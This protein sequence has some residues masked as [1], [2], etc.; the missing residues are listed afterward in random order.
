MAFEH[1]LGRSL[2]DIRKKRPPN[3]FQPFAQQGL[4]LDSVG[5]IPTPNVLADHD[6]TAGILN[7]ST[8]GVLSWAAES[9][10]EPVYDREGT[11]VDVQNT[12]SET[13]IYSK[14]VAAGALSTNKVLRLTMYGDALRNA[15]H[16]PTVKVKL[17]GTTV[18][19][20]VVLWG[21]NSATR[22]PWLMNLMIANLSASSQWVM[23]QIVTG[24]RG[25]MTTGVGDWASGAGLEGGLGVSSADPAVDTTAAC[26]LVVTVTWSGA[27]ASSSWRKRYAI[28]E[29]F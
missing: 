22:A 14:T 4:T 18:L 15:G 20:D 5:K 16:N 7:V 26:D 24:A 11:T 25:S 13:T 27:S 29:L 3:S 19:D 6:G 10:Y 28:L 12:T 17:G 21:S 8:A 2:E 9:T 23:G 1:G